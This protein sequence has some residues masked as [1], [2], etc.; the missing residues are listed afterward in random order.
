MP[1]VYYISSVHDAPA[2]DR[3]GAEAFTASQLAHLRGHEL[4]DADRLDAKAFI[5]HLARDEFSIDVTHGRISGHANE[6][7]TER[8]LTR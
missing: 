4:T 1:T 6:T 5:E 2:R 7:A 8:E 3:A